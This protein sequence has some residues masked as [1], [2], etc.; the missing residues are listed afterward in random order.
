MLHAFD[1][2][3]GNCHTSNLATNV[4]KMRLVAPGLFIPL[5][6]DAGGCQSPCYYYYYSGRQFWPALAM[7]IVMLDMHAYR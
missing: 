4:T 5:R 1:D 7:R 3:M 6:N 2:S